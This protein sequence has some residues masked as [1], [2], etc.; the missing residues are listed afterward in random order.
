MLV[1]LIVVGLLMGLLWLGVLLVFQ[2][3]DHRRYDLPRPV[4]KGK[5]D[6]ESAELKA[7][8]QRML[9][10]RAAT[11]KMS[12]K[13]L[14]E[15]LRTQMDDA[16]AEFVGSA[17]IRPVVVDGIN[18]EWVMTAN[19]D[20]NRRILYIHG[21]AYMM[22]SPKSHRPITSRLSEIAN[23]AVLA[24]DY[25]LMPENRRMAGINDCQ[26]AYRWVLENGPE[27]RSDVGVL[28]VAGD[29]A[30]G[31]LA[32]S[33]IAWARDAQLRPADAV[34]VF[35]PQTDL[36]LAS[37]SL[38]SNIDT[39]ILLGTSFGPMVNTRKVIALSSSFLMNR[40]NPSNALVSPL[41]GDL[42]GLPPTLVQASKVEML[43]D[44]AVR[45]VNKANAQG[46]TAII[47]TWPFTPHVWQAFQTP[48]ADEAF[49]AVEEFLSARTMNISSKTS[50]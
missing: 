38:H 8:T 17:K 2:G 22:G 31:N 3:S 25:R 10:D 42:S 11:P 32:L 44:D 46:S 15:R 7:V 40:I 47:Q 33:T 20:P 12:R 43:L 27:G 35:S 14:L 5:R 45:Y 29:S 39:D 41:F 18:A 28:I 24:I 19:A 26:D 49:G 4:A 21:G 48:E 6:C 37:P 9:D 1:T 13:R 30:G 16:G 23:A 36:T 50:D 34:V